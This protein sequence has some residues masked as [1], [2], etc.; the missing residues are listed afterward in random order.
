M[1]SGLLAGILDAHGGAARWRRYAKVDA[2]I[3]SNGC[4]FALKH[5]VPASSALRTAA[6]TI[7]R[8]SGFHLANGAGR[9]PLTRCEW[10]ATCRRAMAQVS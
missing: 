9:P 2:T 3:V 7:R 6:G 4:F 1:T 5:L 10:P 8:S